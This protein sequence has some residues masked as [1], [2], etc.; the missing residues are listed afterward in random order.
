[1]KFR[2]VVLVF[3]AALALTSLGNPATVQAQA[4]LLRVTV[5]FE[6][7]FGDERL[8]AGT[9]TIGRM[10]STDVVR[11]SDEKGNVA[12]ALTNGADTAPRDLSKSQVVF[13]RYGDTYFLSEVRWEQYPTARALLMGSAEVEIAK[14][15]TKQRVI[16]VSAK[17]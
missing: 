9:Y 12:I 6:F 16:A 5:P 17:R 15:T 3:L 1:M 7:Y 8:P 14:T 13:N 10:W 2:N 11:I 4:S